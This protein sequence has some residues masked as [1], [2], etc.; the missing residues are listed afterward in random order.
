VLGYSN[1]VYDLDALTGAKI[2][3]SATTTGVIRP[4]QVPIEVHPRFLCCHIV[5]ADVLRLRQWRG[6][7]V[8][9]AGQLTSSSS[10]S[11]APV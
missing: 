10:L 9:N 8:R 3:R 7:R 2:W 5:G 11:T 1:Y 4:I 6:A